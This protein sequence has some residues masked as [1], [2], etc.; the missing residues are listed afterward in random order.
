MGGRVRVGDARHTVGV[1]VE[2]DGKARVEG[3]RRAKG[4]DT[5]KSLLFISRM[6]LLRRGGGSF[7]GLSE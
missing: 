2:N 5:R 7:A 3:W 4:C 1:W 6:G